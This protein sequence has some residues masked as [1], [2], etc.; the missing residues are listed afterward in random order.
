MLVV[1]NLPVNTGDIRNVGLTPGWGRSPGG[2]HGN[3]HQYSFLEN[4]MD[5]VDRQATVHRMAKSQTRLKQLS[6]HTCTVL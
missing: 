1:K 5:R 6:T 2:W 3:P 4:P